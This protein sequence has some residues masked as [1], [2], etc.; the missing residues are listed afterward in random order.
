MEM[1]ICIGPLGILPNGSFAAGAT[2]GRFVV[3]IPVLTSAIGRLATRIPVLTSADAGAAVKNAQAKNAQTMPLAA[4]APMRL[5]SRGNGD[6][7]I[8]LAG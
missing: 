4:P 2:A 8:L 5:G 1:K 7:T 6:K 3:R